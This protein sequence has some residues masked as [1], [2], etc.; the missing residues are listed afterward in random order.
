MLLLSECIPWMTIGLAESV[1]IATLNL[2][3]IIVFMKNRNLRK[4]GTYL[5]INLA[6][7]D[8]LAGGITVHRV[9]YKVGAE[10]NV[11]KSHLTTGQDFDVVAVLRPLFPIS[12]LTNITIIALERM[13]ATFRP[14][15]HSVLKKSV[16]GVIIAVV[17]VKNVLVATAIALLRYFGVFAANFYLLRLRNSF[18]GLCLLIIFV[19]Y[20]SIVVKVRCGAQPQHHGAASRE[21]K[22]TMTLLIVTVVSLL[23]YLP[24]VIIHILI[25]LRTFKRLRSLSSS[26]VFHLNNAM[27]VLYYA[28]H[29]V[30]PILYAIRMPEFRTTFLSLINFPKLPQRQRRVADLPLRDV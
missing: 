4:R 26:G 1:A 3:T 29:L 15:K 30:N 16:Y 20:L 13:H 12:S 23:L 24:F 25:F 18:V 8:M 2:C 19:A 21:R 27:F 10:C 17:W 7:I 9:F 22:L 14:F 28:N 6:I 11:W 5:L